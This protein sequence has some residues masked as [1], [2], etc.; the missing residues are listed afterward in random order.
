MARKQ[1]ISRKLKLEVRSA[2]AGCVCCGTWDA[3]DTGHVI[4]EARGGS[5]DISNL[6]LMCSYCNGALRSANAEFSAYA[7]PNDGTRAIVE[8]NRAA[9]INYC[10][11][12][13]A[14]WNAEDQK[15]N[16]I[17]K[18]NP[19]KKPKAYAAPL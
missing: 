17:I 16:G 6:R 8:T 15:D 19:Y 3:R 14:Y 5:L 12:A 1:N 10:N 13:I 18:N 4:A 7:T 11:A 9:W 2:Y